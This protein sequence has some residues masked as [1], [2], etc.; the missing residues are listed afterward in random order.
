MA[1]WMRFEVTS[2]GEYG[3]LIEMQPDDLVSTPVVS[4][5]LL[6]QDF[7]MVLLLSPLHR[8]SSH[9]LLTNSNILV[10]DTDG[11]H[12][13]TKKQLYCPKPTPKH[14]EEI[15]KRCFLS[16]QIVKYLVM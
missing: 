4:S 15:P 7:L 8:S 9:I 5:T 16:D 10:T 13:W 11:T 1:N 12:W 6:T 14:P 2:Q 3:P